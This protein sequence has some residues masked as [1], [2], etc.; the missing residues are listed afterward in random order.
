MTEQE[1]QD[2]N[3]ALAA[4]DLAATRKASLALGKLR[5][6]EWLKRNRQSFRSA[7]KPTSQ[8]GERRSI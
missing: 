7:A 3:N 1:L 8:K 2:Y 6:A 5:S 4:C